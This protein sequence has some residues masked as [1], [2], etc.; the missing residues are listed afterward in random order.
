MRVPA[1]SAAVTL[2]S[3]SIG[4]IPASITRTVNG[5]KVEATNHPAFRL[6]A[7]AANDRVSA[8]KL[9]E[10]LIFDALTTGN[11]YAFANR[12]NGRVIETVRLDPAAVSIQLDQ[13]TG[14]AIYRS[15]ANGAVLDPADLIH[16]PAPVTFDGVTGVSPIQLARE[17]IALAIVLEQRAARLFGTS[18]R[19]AGVIQAPQGVT[20][21]AAAK[22]KA[23]WEASHG[24]AEVSGK[25]PV[26]YDG[27]TF[28]PLIF[29]SVDAQFIESRREQTVEIARAFNVPATMLQ[30][31]QH[32]TFSNTEQMARQ[33]VTYTLTPWLSTIA[34]ELERALLS[35]EDRDDHS[36]EFDTDAL[37]A[38]DT[39]TRVDRIQKLR[40]AGVLTA[41]DVRREEGYPALPDGDTLA[42]PFTTSNTNEITTET[43]LNSEAVNDAA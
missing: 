8:G 36:I 19:P 23:S 41:N 30:E 15:T 22:A 25:T 1:V 9:R 24:G 29:S 11:G 10:R 43:S 16:V 3:T 18:A 20:P 37:L 31:L 26:L 39:A 40:S 17:A 38:V 2:I 13:M 42:S 27:M 32:G 4:S 35:D 33:F 7:K 21:E 5:S 34:G 12:V 28:E 6:V 14:E